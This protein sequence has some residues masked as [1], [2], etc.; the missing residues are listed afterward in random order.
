MHTELGYLHCYIDPTL[1]DHFVTN[2]NLYAAARQAAAW[3][4]TT[5]EKMWR[6]L[7]VRIHQGIVVLPELHHYWQH[8]YRDEY[9]A[10]LMTRNRFMD[11]HRYF[12]I[13]PPVDRGV[14]QTVVE[15]T[16][17]FYHQ[18]QRLFHQY[19][20][21]GRDF[22]VDETMIRF[23]GRSSWIT[24]TVIKNKPV[25]V[26]YKLFTVASEGYLLGFRIY[27]GK[28]DYDSPQSVLHH[29]VVDLVP[30]VG[31]TQPTAVLRQPLH[32]TDPVR[33]FAGDA[34]S[35][36]WYMPVQTAAVCPPISSK[37]GTDF[38]RAR[39]VL[40]ERPAGLCGME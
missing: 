16:A 28:G 14:L 23:R 24:V 5:T 19:Y 36:V 31:R 22:A 35:F 32:Y 15:K 3:V 1:I 20:V 37:L 26:G 39:G 10:Q 40:A 27:R 13:E 6:Y 18:C 17:T 11:L 12:H 8:R 2:T 4:D 7:A 38:R 30:T 34:H 25:P 29:V 9:I 33:S 21:P